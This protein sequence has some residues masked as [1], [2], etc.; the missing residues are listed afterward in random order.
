M[1]VEGITNK[2]GLF[3]LL[4]HIAGPE[5]QDIFPDLPDPNDDF[6]DTDARKVAGRDDDD[7]TK[8]VRRRNKYFNHQC[9]PTFE[10]HIFRQMS[11]DTGESADQFST[12][13]RQQGNLCEF[14]SEKQLQEHMRDQQ[15]SKTKDK[16]RQQ[17]RL[18]EQGMT[19]HKTLELLR[20][21]ESSRSQSTWMSPPP[22]D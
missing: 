18:S 11:P 8:A 14:G 4:L 21:S 2:D 7:Y 9:N 20:T 19:L 3:N 16:S 6:L 1:K 17:R 10:R 22:M 12:R 15:I 5:I 13:L